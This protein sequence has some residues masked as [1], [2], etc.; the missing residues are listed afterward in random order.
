MSFT[1]FELGL[2]K[3]IYYTPNIQS[4]MQDDLS[5]AIKLKLT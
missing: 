5:I 2:Q 4:T 3:H 1:N